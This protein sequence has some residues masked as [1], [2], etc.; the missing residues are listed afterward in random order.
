MDI[1]FGIKQLSNN[2]NTIYHLLNHVTKQE[3]TWKQSPQKWNL[4]EIICHLYDEERED[5]RLRFKNVIETPDKRPPS[6]DP[7]SWVTD[8]KYAEQNYEDKLSNFMMER[9][10][11]IQYLKDLKQPNLEQGYEYG[12]FGHVNGYFFLA[13]WIAHDLLHIKQIARLK[14]DYIA[15]LSKPPIDYAG[16]WT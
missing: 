5:F 10:K 1:A 16:T 3:Y 14:Y 2:K 12:K 15:H 6:F 13:N 11:S 8:R 9:D 7:V 4:L